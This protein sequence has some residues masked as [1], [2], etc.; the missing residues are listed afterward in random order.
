[1]ANYIIYCLPGVY[2]FS[3]NKNSN[4]FENGLRNIKKYSLTRIFRWLAIICSVGLILIFQLNFS[5]VFLAF[6]LTE[7]VI[8]CY[9]LACHY[10][11][12]KMNENMN[13]YK[14]HFNYGYTNVL[15]SVSS[16]LTSNLLILIS[17]YYLSNNETSIVSFIVT[18]SYVFYIISSTIQINFNPVFAKNWSTKNLNLVMVA[19]GKIFTISIISFLPLL[20]FIFLVY[21]AYVNLFM[22]NE[23][24]SS[25]G[26]FVIINLGYAFY[27]LFSWPATMLN[28]SGH[29]MENLARTLMSISITII[30]TLL[31]VHFYG[32]NGLAVSNLLSSIS[33]VIIT[34]Y[35]I[36]KF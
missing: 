7:L 29:V 9:F 6:V 3:L 8:F 16:I 14:V 17:G 19:I 34:H 5:F 35:F 10:R 20:L 1:M 28:M 25:Y 31:L 32:V 22:P 4:S 12:F 13:W 2:F 26:I 18:F 30:L 36:T 15:S 24:Q 33:S 11:Y 21:Y 23:F 27:F